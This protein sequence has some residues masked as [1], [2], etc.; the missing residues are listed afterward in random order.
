M[1]KAK[2][3]RTKQEA[4][5]CPQEA[6]IDQE[7]LLR[8][9]NLA[10]DGG[11]KADE[12]DPQRSSALGRTMASTQDFTNNQSSKKQIRHS[13]QRVPVNDEINEIEQLEVKDDFEDE[14]NLNV[15]K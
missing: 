3:Q 10:K 4:E 7:Q 11:Y 8:I 1:S 14:N 2:S 15:A 9:Q 6:V 12:H 13:H 5:V